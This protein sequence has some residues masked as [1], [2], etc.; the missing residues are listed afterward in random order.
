MRPQSE[1]GV[2]TAEKFAIMSASPKQEDL[3]TEL[4]LDS[5]PDL[6]PERR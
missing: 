3:V 4:L 5:P 6:L 1:N 2:T